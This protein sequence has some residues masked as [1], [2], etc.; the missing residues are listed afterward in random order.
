MGCPS[1]FSILSQDAETVSLMEVATLCNNAVVGRH[2]ELQGSPTE[3]AL[4]AA[5]RDMDL[6]E[7]RERYTRLQE[8]PFS[9]ETKSMAVK[10]EAKSSGAVT[11]FLKGAPERISAAC[12]EGSA[13]LRLWRI[14]TG[15]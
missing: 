4:L 3:K 7:L 5:A 15:I 12:R 9:G 2:A 1:S 11:Y 14:S 13:L 6:S 8:T 10:C